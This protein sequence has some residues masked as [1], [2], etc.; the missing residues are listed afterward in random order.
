MKENGEGLPL[1][2]VKR[3]KTRPVSLIVCI[4]F[5]FVG[6]VNILY[7]FSSLSIIVSQISPEITIRV[8]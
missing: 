4:N 5:V 8:L 7:G 2:L 6:I 1:K 3:N